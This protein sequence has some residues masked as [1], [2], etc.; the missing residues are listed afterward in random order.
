LLSC[1]L[2]GVAA[3]VDDDLLDLPF[4]GQDGREPLDHGTLQ[5]DPNLEPR[6]DLRPQ[7]MQGLFFRGPPA[8]ERAWV[9]SPAAG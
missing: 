5:L 2:D 1:R 9:V 4:V 8:D 6:R 3:Q 7:Q